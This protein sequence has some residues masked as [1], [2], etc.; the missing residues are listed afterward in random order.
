MTTKDRY[1]ELAAMSR[2]MSQQAWDRELAAQLD[3]I[4]TD[5]ER[6][7]AEQPDEPSGTE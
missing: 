6:R 4:A 1:R 3:R 7:A 2:R 5:Y